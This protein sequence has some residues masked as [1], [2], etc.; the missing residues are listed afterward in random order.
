[1]LGLRD[2]MAFTS[3]WRLYAIVAEPCRFSRSR[4][5]EYGESAGAQEDTYPSPPRK[6]GGINLLP[7]HE[8]LKGISVYC[9]KNAAA[10]MVS[11]QRG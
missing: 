7:V 3:D 6:Q 8:R 11:G 2:N 9:L 5:R 4:I 10:R 1:M